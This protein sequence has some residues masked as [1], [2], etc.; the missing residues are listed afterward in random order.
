MELDENYQ[1]ALELI[2]EAEE[3]NSFV[4]DLSGFKL[5][6]I[7][8]KVFE[9]KNLRNLNLTGNELTKLPE[10]IEKLAN[11][12]G[13]I[14]ADN[15]LTRLPESIGNLTNLTKLHLT[16]NKLTR[17]PESIGNLTDLRFI[18]VNKNRLTA[19]PESI[20][21]LTN[22]KHLAIGNN[23]LT[24]L[25]KF[26]ENLISIRSL[27]LHSNRLIEFPKS[28]VSLT[29]LI[30]LNLI[31]NQLAR[32]PKDISK[33]INLRLLYLEDNKL[34]ILPE[35]F[36]KLASLKYLRLG[37]NQLTML[38]KTF[39]KLTSLES[40]YLNEN[41]LK[42]LPETFEKLTNITS[43]ELE[44]NKFKVGE[45]LYKLTPIEQIQ[46]ILKWQRA[47]KAGTLQSIHEAKVIFI[48]ESNY[49]KTH[50]IEFLRKG[51]IER[52]INTTHGI[53]RSQIS[54]PYKAKGI[55]LNIWDL[56]GQEFM[57]STHQFF[58]SERTLYVLVTLA[59]RERNELN[60]WLKLVNQL[61]NKAPVLV[62]IN[63]I[64][65]DPHDLDRKS[66]ERDYPNII[67]FVRTTIKNCDEAKAGVTLEIL[68]QK[69]SNIVSNKK[70]MPSV[71]EQRPAEWFTVKEELENLESK[72]NDFITY[73]EYENLEFIK[74]LP[75]SERKINLKLLSMIGAVVS[76][77]DDPRLID[78][79]VINP[80]WI[81]DGVYAIINDP[82]VKDELK[83]K[84]QIN[85]LARILPKKKFP[86]GRHVY[87]LE[88]M[89]KFNLCYPAK[90]QRDIYFIPDL[91]D[92]IEPDFEWE[93]D[94]F[95]H[96]RYYYDD[97]SPDA[98]M[99]RFIVEMHQDIIDNKRWR[100]GVFI[101][102][103][104]CRA[105]VYQAYRKN[106][107]HVE[108]MGN[109]GE[110]RS[111]LYAIRET[112]RKLHKPFPQMEIV[113][114]VFYEGY[115]LDY[116]ELNEL[117]NANQSKYHTGLKTLLPITDILN[118]Y[119][120]LAERK[121]KLR[122]VKIFL[123]SSSELKEEREQFE[124]FIN[125][126]NNLLV[127]QG[128]YL[129][130]ELWEDFI[131][132]MSKT[133]LQDEYNIVVKNSDIFVS[134][135][136]TKVGKFTHE[137]FETA[138]GEFQKNGKPLIYTYFKAAP[139]NIEDITDEIKTLLSFKEKLKTLGHFR[140]VFKNIDDLKFQFK[141]QLEKILPKM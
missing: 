44:N 30:T 80:Q 114:E 118:G 49:G 89:E 88:L 107:I 119:T 73:E 77:V 47:E 104:T 93:G 76:F 14:L 116:L 132:S 130:L 124:I 9:L 3:E 115:W 25:P 113:Q 101:S 59:R 32:L 33:L 50:L 112:F 111:Y 16:S 17:L 26:L 34:T 121:G 35:T 43:L 57:R 61:G 82:K 90:D 120:S 135:F 28:I 41:Q 96:F 108:I 133:R 127:E 134:L 20:G 106:Y 13:L 21:K 46:E 63:K 123:A 15:L 65:L 117:E 24:I 11:L 85:D 27:F 86:R 71:F 100:S 39:G 51:E 74:N 75:E 12:T 7:P 4:L 122:I 38:P 70:I 5:G 72:G 58:F 10:S 110:G 98:F 64:D 1:K 42:K 136:F 53:E 97:F 131:D 138:F 45:E 6:E 81:M 62:V 105:K 84:L 37:K 40:L 141:K 128:V 103:G 99:T 94:E 109:I 125:R 36:G 140:T 48:G 92:D 56:G 22:L 60:H 139:I 83:G 102:N 67:G 23:K 68:K 55:R 18:V 29:S 54:V 69:I 66:L 8:N 31:N 87:L 137:E 19:L 95:I 91:F 52:D 126:E 79:N 78:T 129:K 2:S